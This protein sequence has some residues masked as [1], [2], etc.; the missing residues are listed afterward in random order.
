[1]PPPQRLSD[2]VPFPAARL[3]S[4]IERSGTGYEVLKVRVLIKVQDRLDPA[5]SRRMPPA[6]FQQTAR[7]HVEQV[8]EVEGVRLAKLDRERL[9]EDVFR[10]AFGFGPLEELFPDPTVKEILVLGPQAVVVLR[11]HGWTPTNV[12]FRDADQV[13]EVLERVAAHGEAV[14]SGLAHSAIDVRLPNGFRAVAV[15]P[16]PVLNQP[17]T[18]VFVRVEAAEPPP[19]PAAGSSASGTIARPGFPVNRTPTAVGSPLASPAPGESQLNRHRAR[20]TER[21][22]AKMA[23]VGMYDLRRVEI[24]ELR[25][26][27][28]A[29]VEEYCRLEKIYL[30]DTDQGK[31]T[32]EILTGMN[33]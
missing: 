32:L 25:R 14:A 7:Q 9:V 26:V 20:I 6:L 27:V 31:L 2:T 16:P 11:E 5:K 10:E 18:A 3:A 8:V 33:R 30:S 23:S 17:P 21:I 13:L 1:M 28:A 29:Y 19:P 24:T 22:I 12:K 15:L 4:G